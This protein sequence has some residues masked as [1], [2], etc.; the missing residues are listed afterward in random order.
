MPTLRLLLHRQLQYLSGLE[1]GAVLQAVHLHSGQ[2]DDGYARYDLPLPLGI[3]FSQTKADILAFLPPPDVEGGGRD[4][5]FGPIS[6]WFRY[7]DLDG[8]SVHINFTSNAQAVEVVTLML[9]K[10]D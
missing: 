4:G 7:D 8:H 10:K 9:L 2:K 6:E 5:Y 1:D 3:S